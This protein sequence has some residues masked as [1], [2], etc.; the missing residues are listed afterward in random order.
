MARISL[1]PPR[2]MIVRAGEWYT[3]RRFG[4]ALDPGR[5]MAHNRRVLMTCAREEMSAEKWSKAPKE[6]KHLAVMAAAA[7]VGCQWCMDFGYWLG[8]DDGIDPAKIHELPAWRDSTAY[9]PLERRV[10]AFAE[11]MSS[12]PP[13]VTDA[14]VAE[15]RADLDE[16]QLV[17]L[18]MII[19]VENQRARFND[20]LGLASQGFADRCEL[21]PAP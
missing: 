11:A 16:A 12:T 5:A 6:L 18:T 17:E 14:M 8:M 7:T 4:V 1:D 9:T 10:I 13:A 2:T 21:A 3:R 20:A 15:L 19:A